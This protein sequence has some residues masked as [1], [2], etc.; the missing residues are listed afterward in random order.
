MTVYVDD[1]FLEATVPH[2]GRM[3]TSRWCHMTADTRAELDAMAARIGLRPE[4]IQMPSTWK[5][6]YDLTERRRA[7]AVREG[8][9]EV[10]AREHVRWLN[11]RRDA[12]QQPGESEISYLAR[13]LGSQPATLDSAPE[14]TS[15]TLFD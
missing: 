3:L 7:A 2:R 6:H 8:A 13:V 10:N 11:A 15:L 9:L 14:P 1:A 5:E 4:W 12:P